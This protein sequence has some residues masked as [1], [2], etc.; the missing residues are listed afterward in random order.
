MKRAMVVQDGIIDI[1]K[2]VMVSCF[3]ENGEYI[4]IVEMLG[5]VGFDETYSTAEEARIRMKQFEEAINSQAPMQTS[6]R[7]LHTLNM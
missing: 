5:G 2:I 3:E 4:F 7:N 6:I 1:S